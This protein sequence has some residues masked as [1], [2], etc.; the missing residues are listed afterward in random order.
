[1]KVVRHGSECPSGF[2]TPSGFFQWF[3]GVLFDVASRTYR[4]GA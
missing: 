1:M 2:S 4:D 3:H